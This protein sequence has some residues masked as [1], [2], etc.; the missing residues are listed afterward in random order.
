VSSPFFGENEIIKT[1]CPLHTTVERAKEIT[2][3][4]RWKRENSTISQAMR[5]QN[6]VFCDNLLEFGTIWAEKK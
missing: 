2:R 1:K 5:Q 3:K 4:M 6:G